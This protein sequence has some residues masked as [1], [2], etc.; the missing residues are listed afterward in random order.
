MLMIFCNKYRHLVNGQFDTRLFV[1]KYSPDTV[2]Y[3]SVGEYSN[4]YIWHN[5][6]VEVTLFFIREKQVRH[7]YSVGLCQGEVLES[8][9]EIIEFEPL[10]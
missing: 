4:V 3:W 6:I 7:P 10:I 1:H 8:A 5:D 2:Q 9:P